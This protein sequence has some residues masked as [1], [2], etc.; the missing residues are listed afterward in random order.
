MSGFDVLRVYYVKPDRSTTGNIDSSDITT[1]PDP[2]GNAN[3]A[4]RFLA[5]NGLCDQ[6]GE[7]LFYPYGN[8][9]GP[10]EVIV[11][12]RPPAKLMVTDRVA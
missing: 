10:P 12:G 11:E 5:P 8:S 4:V 6:T 2:D 7:Y 9:T 1:V 3:Y